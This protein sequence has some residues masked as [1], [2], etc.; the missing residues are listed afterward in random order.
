MARTKQ[1]KIKNTHI[2]VVFPKDLLDE[3]DALAERL[4]VKE[5]G[6]IVTRSYVVRRA[7]YAFLKQDTSTREI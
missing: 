6:T 4:A 5:P 1:K 3:V 7:V 2:S